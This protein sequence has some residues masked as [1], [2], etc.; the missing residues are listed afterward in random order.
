MKKLIIILLLHIIFFSNINFTIASFQIETNLSEQKQ[1]SYKK[2]V[3][4][5]YSDFE[6]KLINIEN[7]KQVFKIQKIVE[8]INILL[9][10]HLSDKNNF[11]LSYLK[12]LLTEKLDFLNDDKVW[13]LLTDN[14]ECKSW[15]HIEWWSCINNNK[16]C[17]IQNWNWQQT[18]NWLEWSSCN[19]INCDYWYSLNNW[20]CSKKTEILDV[21]IN[22]QIT[23]RKCYIENWEWQ[24]TFFNN[25]WWS[26]EIVSCNT[27]YEKVNNQCL[28]KCNSP[29]HRE[30]N[31]CILNPI[32]PPII[33]EPENNIKISRTDTNVDWN[34]APWSKYIS[35]YELNISTS[36]RDIELTNLDFDVNATGN[37]EGNFFWTLY[38]DWKSIESKA[39]IWNKITFDW[40]FTK[41]WAKT[42]KIELIVD[43]GNSY[44]D[45]SFSF[46]L[47]SIKY[48][49]NSK[50]KE[51]IWNV[52]SSALFTLKQAELI[53]SKWADYDLVSVFRLWQSYKLTW[54]KLKALN[55]D[56]SI[57]NLKF[58]W[59]WFE[60]FH[61]FKISKSW[62][63]Y[64]TYDATD[65]KDYLV[66][67]INFN[68]FIIKKWEEV[69]V[70]VDATTKND[71][72][73]D[74]KSFKMDFLIND[75]DF[76]APDWSI[77]KFTWENITI[78]EKVINIQEQE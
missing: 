9:E 31:I 63:N 7:E 40:K 61:S 5:V 45:W 69:Y 42:S 23:S 68:D 71:I 37:Y 64:K 38:I 36:V 30:W 49:D 46:K 13:G 35:V 78:N 74:G 41:I 48:N 8:K 18:W 59:F 15:E 11:V 19:I 16:S 67:F 60:N 34:I 21:N 20:V 39:V 56:V 76:R 58:S 57:K 32:N 77:I 33:S 22:N 72:K 66:T 53:V 6:S 65:V 73:I 2:Q 29:S 47:S 24:E 70:S 26:C 43:L 51:L 27:W 44:K 4:S 10:K 17:Y 14:N 75:G 1:E 12:F 55:G 3:N 25:N 50:E 52:A 62:F 54:F 28:I